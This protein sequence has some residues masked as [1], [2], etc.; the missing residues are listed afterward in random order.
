MQK[1]F[2]EIAIIMRFHEFIQ[3]T[4]AFHKRPHNSIINQNFSLFIIQGAKFHN[5]FA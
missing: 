1:H 4:A 5:N 3:I 2:F